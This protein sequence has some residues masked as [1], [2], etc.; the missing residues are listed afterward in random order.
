MVLVGAT[1]LL[2]GCG[3]F[4]DSERVVGSADQEMARLI[5]NS[6]DQDV[7]TQPLTISVSVQ[8]GVATLRGVITSEPQ[9][10]RALG[11]ARG[12]EGVV[13]VEDGLRLVH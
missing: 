3:T 4:M 5:Q 7:I 8:N 2:V 11:I 1:F 6:L 13:K 9:R 12:V 10:A